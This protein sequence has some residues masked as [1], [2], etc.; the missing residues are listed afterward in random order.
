M[1]LLA[2]AVRGGTEERSPVPLF[3][4]C[5]SPEGY[6]EDVRKIKAGEAFSLAADRK[7]W[8]GPPDEKVHDQWLERLAADPLAKRIARLNL[9][10]CRRLN[11]PVFRSL[12]HFRSL[13]ALDLRSTKSGAARIAY[14]RRLPALEELHI[15][16]PRPRDEAL[17]RLALLSGLRDL[18]LGGEAWRHDE[19]AQVAKLTALRRLRLC[20]EK[21]EKPLEVLAPLQQLESLDLSFSGT[22]DRDLAGLPRLPRLR[23]LV[24]QRTPIRGEG[25]RH[26]RGQPALEELDVTFCARLEDRALKEIAALEGLRRLDAADAV[27]SSCGTTGYVFGPDGPTCR[28]TGAG[29]TYLAG[30]KHLEELRLVALPLR[31]ADLK[32]LHGLK[33]LKRLDLSWCTKLSD[34]A[35][36]RLRAALP[37]CRVDWNRE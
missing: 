18:D 3:A 12:V 25:L 11:D 19:I 14:L 17:G 6:P 28:L 27:I 4:I 24:L 16:P 26:L 29:L 8:I 23:R 15:D 5:W 34:K 20:V 37:G 9:F 33:S 21:G 10:G 32:P 36:Q 31:D 30:A 13:R 7:W 1:L 22:R 2:G 35:V